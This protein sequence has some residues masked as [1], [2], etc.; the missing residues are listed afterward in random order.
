MH[1]T[2]KPPVWFWVL[3]GLLT[4]WGI[5]GVA[6]LY[7]DLSTTATDRAKLDAYDQ[8]LYATRPAWFVACYGVAVWS[9][10][11]GSLLL[12]ARRR[13]AGPLYVVSLIAVLVMFGWMFVATDIIAHKG[14]LVATGFPIVIA[15]LCLFELWV[16]GV[17]RRHGWVA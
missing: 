7:L 2:T 1:N 5:V 14:V 4:L 8:Q 16:V 13:I 12:L 17:A 3:T 11:I 10:L 9:G 6:G 15:L